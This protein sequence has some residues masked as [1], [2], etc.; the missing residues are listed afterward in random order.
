MAEQFKQQGNSY[1]VSLEYSNA[2][3][4]YNKCLK[5]VSDFPTSED[6]DLEMIKVVI[7]NRA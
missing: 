4:C 2:I 1:F 5:A 6:A 3:D 7:S